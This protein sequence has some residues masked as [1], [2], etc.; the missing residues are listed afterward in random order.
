MSIK[1]KANEAVLSLEKL[2]VETWTEDQEL[3]ARKVI[4]TAMLEAVNELCE[5]S[6][7]V[8]NQCCSADQDMAHKINDE[9]RRAKNAV[10]ANLSSMR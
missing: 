5:H 9:L 7:K 1:V 4:E 6:S 3:A 2:L 10:L 8:V